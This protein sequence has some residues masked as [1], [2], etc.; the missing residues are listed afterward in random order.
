MGTLEIVIIV[1]VGLIAIF[2][3]YSIF[4]SKKVKAIKSKRKEQKEQ[5]KAEK[6]KKKQDKKQSKKGASEAAGK[7]RKIEPAVVSKKKPE[8]EKQE[9]PSPAPVPAQPEPE[10]EKKKPEPFRIIRKTSQVKINK[11]A[12]KNGSRNPSIT[13]VFENGKRID[14][15][16]PQEVGPVS[17]KVETQETQEAPVYEI[18]REDVGDFGFREPKYLEESTE[19]GFR[20]VPPKGLPN[21]APIIGDRTNFTSRLTVSSD[22]NLSGVSGPGINK[23]IESVNK[24]TEKIEKKTVDLVEEVRRKLLGEKDKIKS[25]AGFMGQGYDG[26]VAEGE[27]NSINRFKSIDAETLI[28]ADAI[29]NPKYKKQ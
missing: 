19:G 8:A 5:K 16:E 28:I 23:A 17:K 13:K 4:F 11:K 20:I 26:F 3:L 10:L 15:V 27:Q 7:E 9:P 14:A 1:F 25:Q 2:G 18:I 24:Q 22:N 29:S 12:L 21:R 6:L